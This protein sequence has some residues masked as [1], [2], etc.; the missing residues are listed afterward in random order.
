[1]ITIA[2]LRPLLLA[3]AATFALAAAPVHADEDRSAAKNNQAVAEA[4]EDGSS[5]FDLAFAVRQTASE[6]VDE[7]NSAI[8]YASCA[9]CRAVAIAFQ[10]VIV[11][12]SPSTVTPQNLAIAVNDQCSGCSTLALA[13]QFVIGR[14]EPVRLTR[15]G[16]QRLEQIRRDLEKLEHDYVTLANDE[17][18]E[19]TDAYADEVRAVLQTELVP[20]REDEDDDRQR[21]PPIDREDRD[22]DAPADGEPAPAPPTSTTSPTTTAAPSESEPPPSSTTAEPEDGGTT[23]TVP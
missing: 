2:H 12:G 6:V 15:Q 20:V 4:T 5:V 1:M 7:T 16:Q 10:I 14:G 8:A 19:L 9:E 13:Y 22:E 23:T 21:G 17:I 3:L 18:R 11:Q